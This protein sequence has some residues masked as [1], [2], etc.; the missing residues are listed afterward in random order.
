MRDHNPS[1]IHYD[2]LW[3]DLSFLP[4]LFSEN[5][6]PPPPVIQPRLESNTIL[7]WFRVGQ[8]CVLRPGLAWWCC[9]D[10]WLE[11]SVAL[12]VASM[13]AGTGGER[14]DRR[15]GWRTAWPPPPIGRRTTSAG[16]DWLSVAGRQGDSYHSCGLLSLIRPAHP[17]QSRAPHLHI[18]WCL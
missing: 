8:L 4:K 18:Q 7:P 1:F 17:L 9:I 3:K 12:S 14:R 5:L 15:D 10:C 13:T 6:S 16:C 11:L 2:S